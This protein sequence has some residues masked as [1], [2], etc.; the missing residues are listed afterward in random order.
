MTIKLNIPPQIEERIYL[1]ARQAGV[2]TND[3]LIAVIENH[4][5][6]SVSSPTEPDLLLQI[7][8]GFS[9]EKWQT[10]FALLRKRDAANL[11]TTEHQQ[12]I[13]IGEEI[14]QANVRRMKAL[15]QLAQRRQT[16]VDALMG[17]LGIAPL[18]YE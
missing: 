7:N 9:E 13:K 16:N 11:T 1:A 8:L 2:S 17:E 3:Y 12:L 5:V 15:V 10:Y 4:L 6:H 18:S 14:E